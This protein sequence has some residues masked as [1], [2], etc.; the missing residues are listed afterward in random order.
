MSKLSSLRLAFVDTETTGLDPDKHEI[1][2]I[3]C[4]IYDQEKDSV[5]TEWE[6][7]IKPS[8]IE[9]ASSEALRI[10]GYVNNSIEYTG[11]LKPALIKLNSLVKGCVIIG[12][13][14]EFDIRF[15]TNAMKDFDMSPAWR[16]N[17]KLELMSL[18]WK[19]L[20]DTDISGLS[21]A[22]TCSHFGISNEGA[23]GALI[24]CRRA[25]EVYK[26]VT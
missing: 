1:I 3:G 23:H 24:D 8:H 19:D 21:L 26:C 15:L 6:K 17:R 20:K 9:S 7:K 16:W 4:L 5:V 22:A 18:V 10:N 25:Y 2:E 12:Q 13:N 14:I 11:G